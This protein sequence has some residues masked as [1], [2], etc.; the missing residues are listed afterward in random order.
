MSK[1]ARSTVLPIPAE[2]AAQLARKPATMAFVLGPYLKF[3]RLEIP[4]PVEVGT[5]GSA[6]LWCFGIIPLWTHR[7]EVKELSLTEV[8][9]NES[10]GPVH[11]WNHRLIFEPIDDRRCRYTDEVETDEGWRGAPT[12]S[13]VRLLFRH[14]HRR[15][16]TLAAILA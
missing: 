9:T 13:F 14:R 3:R 2:T 7:L 10:G 8:Y 15:W 5:T 1:V 11:T 6:W 4:E 12:R 16:R